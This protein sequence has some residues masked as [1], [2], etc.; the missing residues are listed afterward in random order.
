MFLVLTFYFAH[1]LQVFLPV[2]WADYSLLIVS[3]D[4]QMFLI[5]KKSNLSVLL[6][7]CCLCFGV[8]FFLYFI[9]TVLFV[10]FST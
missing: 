7:F 9:F 10:C 1:N 8:F 2:L 5:L 4:A 6:S 3:F